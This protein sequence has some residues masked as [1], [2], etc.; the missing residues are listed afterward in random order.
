[1]E[2]CTGPDEPLYDFLSRHCDNP[3]DARRHFQIIDR[4][5]GL[6]QAER[7]ESAHILS[8]LLAFC[9]RAGPLPRNRRTAQ[10]DAETFARLLALAQHARLTPGPEA[11][12]RL[13]REIDSLGDI[14]LRR[15]APGRGG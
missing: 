5:T 14:L 7:L 10:I 1:M 11:R 8:A 13:E 4:A 9:E 12:R 2:H 15:D 6:R 3:G